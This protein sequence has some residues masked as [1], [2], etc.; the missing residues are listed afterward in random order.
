MNRVKKWY[1]SQ[2]RGDMPDGLNLIEVEPWENGNGFRFGKFEYI[3]NNKLGDTREECL[4][5]CINTLMCFFRF[6]FE[7][8]PEIEKNKHYVFFSCGK[9]LTEIVYNEPVGKCEICN[10]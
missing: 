2:D 6:Y 9:H 1:Y 7:K 4:E 8:L 3:S 10:E 5:K